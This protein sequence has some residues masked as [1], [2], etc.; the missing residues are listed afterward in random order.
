[1]KRFAQQFKKQSEKTKLTAGERF[2]LREKVTTFMEYHP[3]PAG[4]GEVRTL[5]SLD[6]VFK[7]SRVS[8]KKWSTGLGIVTVAFIVTLPAVAEYTVPGDMLYPVKVRI[9]EEVRSTLA[10]TPYEKVEWESKRIERRIS[11]AR[12]LAKAGLLTP[13]AE[14]AVAAAVT[15]HRSNAN[16]EI[17]FLRE[18]NNNDEAALANMTLASV[19][20]VQST[21]F[22]S[23][24]D[25]TAATS[26]LSSISENTAR[27]LAGVLEGGRAELA[28][29]NETGVISHG[30]LM[31]E[32]E[33]QTT[34]AYER[35]T[36]VKNAVSSQE[37]SDISRRLDDIST[38]IGEAKELPEAKG[39]EQ[40]HQALKDTQ[41][42]IAFMNDIDLRSSITVEKIVPITPTFDERL[43][44]FTPR[45]ERFV[46]KV[47]K[48]EKVTQQLPDDI[49][50]SEIL[51]SIEEMKM[52]IEKSHAVTAKTIREV[53]TD[54]PIM[55]EKAQTL[56]EVI[57][58]AGG[59]FEIGLEEDV[60]VNGGATSTVSA[61]TS[62]PTSTTA[63][64][65]FLPFR[66]R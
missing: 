32:I 40:L 48:I 16:V 62:T 5:L 15:Q 52:Y 59:D 39:T 50:K 25:N 27:T 53:E 42:L 22:R 11:E 10:R 9:N 8:W 58:T 35:L 43:V 18:S 21:A 14:E 49:V 57:I 13:E 19:F 37:A 34:R 44:A 55:K 3:L 24:N 41:K 64:R 31:A 36:S 23:N 29:I 51:L 63:N 45:L 60:E 6:N 65:S 1:M 20:E 33:K 4:E 56:I 30:R 7:T 61:P 2:L 26:S 12:V 38:R 54:L 66:I 28:I 17:A 47:E 46:L